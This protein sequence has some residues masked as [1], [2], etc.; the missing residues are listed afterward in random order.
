MAPV[1]DS[2]LISVGSPAIP[3]AHFTDADLI[4]SSPASFTMS[5]GL[6]GSFNAVTAN[7]PSPQHLWEENNAEPFFNAA[8]EVEDDTGSPWMVRRCA[9]PASTTARGPANEHDL[10]PG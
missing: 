1:G 7:Y 2:Y 10:D 6:A 9:R 3:V 5:S 4:L 8:W